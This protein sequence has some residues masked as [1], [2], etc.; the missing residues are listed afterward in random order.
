MHSTDDLQA[1][2]LTSIDRS[3]QLDL[4]CCYSSLRYEAPHKGRRTACWSTYYRMMNGLLTA[5]TCWSN[6]NVKQINKGSRRVVDWSGHF[7][8]WCQVYQTANDWRNYRRRWLDYQWQWSPT[9][10]RLN[11]Y[12]RRITP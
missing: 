2:K 5:R 12:N 8:E 11:C 9:D 10:V 3:S 7:T 6:D 1:S 4:D